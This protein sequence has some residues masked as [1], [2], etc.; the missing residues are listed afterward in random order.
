VDGLLL[1]AVAVETGLSDSQFT[2]LISGELNAGTRLV[3]GL[4]LPGMTGS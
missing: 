2:E 4:Q 1:R 3:I